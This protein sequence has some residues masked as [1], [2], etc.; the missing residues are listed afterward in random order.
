MSWLIFVIIGASSGVLSG[1][2]GIGGGIVL[3]PALV[4]FAGFSQKLAVGTSLAVLLPPVGIAAALEYYRHGNVDFRVALIVAVS[5]ITG[6]WLG[7]KMANGLDEQS[8]KIAFGLF[9]IALGVYTI[10]KAK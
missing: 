7:A 9:L 2:F 4:Y 8:L 1:I 6:S 3:V 5:L 10:I